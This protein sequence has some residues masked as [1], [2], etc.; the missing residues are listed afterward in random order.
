VDPEGEG[1]GGA[2]EGG[3]L[4]LGLWSE[5]EVMRKKERGPTPPGML[6]ES[7]HAAWRD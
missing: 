1:W 5:G 6:S 2:M 4:E 3:E 7:C